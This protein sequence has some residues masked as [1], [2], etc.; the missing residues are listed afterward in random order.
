MFLNDHFLKREWIKLISSELSINDIPQRY[1]HFVPSMGYLRC[2]TRLDHGGRGCL[3]SRR[4]LSEGWEEAA[5][6]WGVGQASVVGGW[7]PDLRARLVCQWA[8]RQVKVKVAQ[9]CLTLCNPRN[10]TIHGILQAR[11]LEWVAYPFSRGSSQP[12]DWT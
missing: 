8:A 9:L 7:A 3:L 12:R 6:H 11:I 10:Y 2:Y 4:I 5:G 1:G